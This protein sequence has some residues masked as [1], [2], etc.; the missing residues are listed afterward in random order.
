MSNSYRIR[1]EVGVDKS[2]NVYLDQ[3]FE[4]LEILSLKLLQSQIYTRPCADYG[5]VVGR[6]SV[7]NGFGIPNAKVSIFI[8]LTDEDGLNPAI[9]DLYPYKSVSDINDDGYRYNLLPYT[10]QHGGHTPTGTFFDR[11]DVLI[12]TNLIEVYDKYFKYTARTNDS[13]DFMLFGVPLGPQTIHIDIDLSDIGEFSLFPQDL[14]RMGRATQSQ[15]AGTRFKSSNNLNELPQIVGI[16]RTIE[17]EPLWGQEDFCNIGITR[18]DFDLSDGL[19]IKIEP[20]AVFMG[21]IFSSN[22][23]QAQKRNCKPRLNAGKLCSLVA[24]PGEI[25]AIRQTIFQD[26]LGR[27]ALETFA[28]EE[29][30][31]VID[32]NGTWMVDLP[33]N[34]DY[35][36]TNE[37]GE[38][39]LSND[40]S[41]GIP[42]KAKYRFKVKWNQPPTLREPVKRGYFLV[43]NIR[44]YGWGDTGGTDPLTQPTS[45]P[46]YNVGLQSYAF[47]IDWNDY[48]TTG[49]TL[50]EQMIQSAINCED[51]FYEFS[52]NKVYTVAQFIDQFRRGTMPNRITAIKNI[53][54]DTC[55]SDVNKFPTND[56]NLR[57]DIIYLLFVIMLYIFRPIIYLLL[58]VTHILAFF[59]FLIGPILAIVVGVIFFIVIAIC[60]FI[61]IIIDTINLLPRVNIECGVC[62][63]PTLQDLADTVT[64]MLNLYKNFKNLKLPNLTY[65][66]CELCDCGNPGTI[67]DDPQQNPATAGSYSQLSQSGALAILSQYPTIPKYTIP[68]STANDS[69]FYNI[70]AGA[71]VQTSPNETSISRAPQ[72]Y[73]YQTITGPIIETI[74]DI[75][76]TIVYENVP[77]TTTKVLYSQSI[78]LA[79]K[80]NLFNVKAKYFESS[81][82]GGN[83]GGGVNQIEVKFNVDQNPSEYHKDNVIVISCVPGSLSTFTT[84]QLITF[85]EIEKSKDVNLTGGTLNQFGTNSATGETYSQT[86]IRTVYWANPDGTGDVSTTYLITGQTE[87]NGEDGDYHKFPIDI[88]Y[89]QVITAMTYSNFSSIASSNTSLQNSLY[90]RY[91]NGIMNFYTVDRD[92]NQFYNSAVYRPIQY[93]QNAG[94][95]E[96]IVFLVR[97][98]DPYSTR[99]KVSYDLNKLFGNS[100]FA[101]AGGNT[102]LVVQ[103]QYKLNIPI[104]G[105]LKCVDHDDFVIDA[106]ANGL[107]SNYSPNYKLYHKSYRYKPNV[108]G[109]TGEGNLSAFTSNLPSYYSKI[110]ST[111]TSFAP[112]NPSPQIGNLSV[113]TD[114]SSALRLR[115]SCFNSGY[116]ENGFMGYL[117]GNVSVKRCVDGIDSNGINISTYINSTT[118]PIW[119]PTETKTVSAL[120]FACNTSPTH[121]GGYFPGEYIDGGSV[122]A[123]YYNRGFISQGLVR[124]CYTTNFPAYYY[125][126]KYPTSLNL[127][128]DGNPVDKRIIMRSDRLP[129]S[130]VTTNNGGNSSFVLQ[131]NLNFVALQ[132][133]DEGFI[134]L[135]SS[136][137]PIGVPS[138]GG[139]DENIEDNNVSSAIFDSFTCGGLIPLSCYDVSANGEIIIKPTS[140]D[141]YDNGYGTK[142][143]QNGCYVTVTKIFLSLILDFTILAE[144]VSR[145]QI[146][147]G[148]CRNV[149]SHMFTNN[150]INGSL[151][152]FPIN[153][154]RFFTEPN[155]SNPNKPY[156]LYCKKTMILHPTNNYYY[157]CS[158]YSDNSGSFV[159]GIPAQNGIGNDRNIL[160]PTTVVDLG[161]KN[162]FVQ[163]LVMSDKYDGYV[164]NKLP[165]TTFGD[166]DEILNLFIISRLTNT[167][168]LETFF[169]VGG[170]NVLS[171]FSRQKLMVDGDYAQSISVNSELGVAPFQAETYQSQPG[172]PQDPIFFTNANS[173][174]PAF[175]IFFSSDTQLRDWVSPK[176]TII[177]PTG[178]TTTSCVFNN[179]GTFSQEVP[180]Y[181]WNIDDNW[182]DDNI[183]GSED[184]TWY[185]N[186]DIQGGSF[187]K[188][189]Y[190]S[191]DRIVQQC[192]YF[193]PI[194]QSNQSNV[195]GH[196][197]SVTQTNP[198]Q[199]SPEVVDWQTNSFGPQPRSITVG[200]PFYFYFGLKKGKT[201]WDRFAKKW[202][203]LESIE[204]DG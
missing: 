17:V 200:A 62:P 21:S 37:F 160:F 63:C 163:E 6:V 156:S 144:W 107:P 38:Q 152:A 80:I 198:V 49:T 118:T 45:S 56:A 187:L 177:V 115:T 40:P 16:N 143:M 172:P 55:E 186:N 74:Q 28:L 167:S 72:T 123:Q 32:D 82:F 22:E 85:Q 2:V 149:W 81:A 20:T 3:D 30:G 86:Q 122:M 88:E 61:K 34:L 105:G 93:Y 52:Y 174:E 196:I 188:Y 130:T 165:Q 119:E 75:F 18:S 125:S 79:E 120:S 146:N 50:G 197:Y 8:P 111:N 164:I 26:T 33:M 179:Y 173:E 151:Y 12:D 87:T 71:P 127:T 83:P 190:Q 147:F 157:R 78:P 112:I 102:N 59:L 134:E 23:N 100:N 114:S 154:D 158:P 140:N 95:D 121:N 138:P 189:K 194:N 162:L 46:Q 60:N 51:K 57:W 135:P 113:F 92:N 168:F 141:C 98:V 124:P 129:T 27:P 116:F 58:I 153:N 175:G 185:T 14:I 36:I 29:G 11:E 161:P 65:P 170:A 192:R 41:K 77:T 128:Y 195:R 15:V 137:G 148:A 131:T 64:D 126:T 171:Y 176:R 180:F 43:P 99:T 201:A 39:V 48:G 94:A 182:N 68:L 150:W 101:T 31:Q 104:Q 103:G 96:V 110:D 203:D 90:S 73:V 54:D 89:F 184:N 84:G 139:T 53:L 145:I 10:K 183:F 166:I 67:N 66:D 19:N 42:T 159:G 178:N 70:M 199:L 35:V 108:G 106:S 76:P 24:G 5:V 117:S 191:M 97:G 1:T 7:N 25:L 4:F 47:S 91:L 13:G 109:T 181:Q 169:G 136:G 193:R 9:F 204:I 142:I 202:L 133:P 69:A 155:S 44:E 132:V